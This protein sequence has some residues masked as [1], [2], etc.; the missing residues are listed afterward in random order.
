MTSTTL[1]TGRPFKRQ[2]PIGPGGTFRIEP[3]DLQHTK[4]V[5]SND[6][7]WAYINWWTQSDNETILDPLPMG[8]AP[9]PG[10]YGNFAP[11]NRWLGEQL[12]YCQSK[13]VKL[14]AEEVDEL[15]RIANYGA[16]FPDQLKA[17]AVNP[18]SDD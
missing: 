10:P 6:M 4:I 14:S 16:R 3:L 2:P 13:N 8:E 11:W 12:M 18:P 7:L 5:K 17:A 1:V 9:A 15:I